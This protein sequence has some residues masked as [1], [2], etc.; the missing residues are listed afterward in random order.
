MAWHHETWAIVIVNS[1]LVG[2]SNGQF[3]VFTSENRAWEE[4]LKLREKNPDVELV[5]KK[6]KL[7]LPW[8]TYE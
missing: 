8:K 6:T 1:G 3:C 7:P 5:V 4:C 2:T